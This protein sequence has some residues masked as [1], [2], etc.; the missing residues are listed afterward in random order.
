M[1]TTTRRPVPPRDVPPVALC[2]PGDSW[3]AQCNEL[4]H[5]FQEVTFHA[6]ESCVQIQLKDPR[7]PG[8]V[9]HIVWRTKEPHKRVI[10]I[11]EQL[12][13]DE[14]HPCVFLQTKQYLEHPVSLLRLTCEMILTH[15]REYVGRLYSL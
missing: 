7:V 4:S 5:F 8:Y 15:V 3:Q 13:R 1:L 12:P 10:F 11:A 6:D 9:Y 14:A 2:K